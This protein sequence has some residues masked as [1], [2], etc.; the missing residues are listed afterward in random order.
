MPL[1]FQSPR[2]VVPMGLVIL[3]IVAIVSNTP[4]MRAGEVAQEFGKAMGGRAPVPERFREKIARF[5]AENPGCTINRTRSAG[6]VAD[7]WRASFR[8]PDGYRYFLIHVEKVGDG[9][10]VKDF[11]LLPAGPP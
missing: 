6:L 4:T 7:R 2:V 9:F 8:C 3:G 1:N 11:D 10:R 5:R